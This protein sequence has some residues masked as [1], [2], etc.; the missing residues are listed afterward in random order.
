MDNRHITQDPALLAELAEHDKIYGHICKAMRKQP[1]Y[2]VDWP[3][4]DK[5]WDTAKRLHL[6]QRRKSGALYISHPR[7]VMEELARLRC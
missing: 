4:V 1:G 5:A 7:S 3:L 6:D 2:V